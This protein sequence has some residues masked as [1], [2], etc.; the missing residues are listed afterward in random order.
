MSTHQRDLLS[1]LGHDVVCQH[2]GVQGRTVRQAAIRGL[3]PAWYREVKK[4]CES[5][6]IDCPMAAFRWREAAHGTAP[7]V[8]QPVAA[9]EGRAEAAE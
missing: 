6:G 8:G 5:N 3:P 1:K 4:I 2:L 7:A 9:D